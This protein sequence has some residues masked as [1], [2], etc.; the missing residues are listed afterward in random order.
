MDNISNSSKICNF[1]TSECKGRMRL[2]TNNIEIPKSNESIVSAGM[3]LCQIHYNRL[4]FNEIKILII[5][6]IVNIQNMMNIKINPKM[7]IKNQ[8]SLILKRF[9]KD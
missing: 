4:I 1:N 2:V 7:Q 5:I 6:K 8:I 3:Y 9:Q